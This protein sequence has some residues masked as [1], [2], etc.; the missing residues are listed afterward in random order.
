MDEQIGDVVITSWADGGLCLRWR[1]RS[2]PPLRSV[3]AD[4]A[5]MH[6]ASRWLLRAGL[7][8]LVPAVGAAVAGIRLLQIG[9]W[10][11]GV[12]AI[13]AGLVLAS[14]FR[15]GVDEGVSALS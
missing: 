14:V 3:S 10:L 8:L 11:W 5:S 15:Q 13:G 6:E 4:D 2:Q 9:D 12:A 7:V 1:S